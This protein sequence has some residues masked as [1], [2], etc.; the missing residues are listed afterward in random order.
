MHEATVKVKQI[1]ENLKR[2]INNEHFALIDP[3]AEKPNEKELTKR[4]TTLSIN[5]KN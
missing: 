2:R 3:T 4:R 1:C 5:L